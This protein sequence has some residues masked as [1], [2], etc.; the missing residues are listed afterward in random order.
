M[1]L[2]PQF[3]LSL[4]IPLGHLL[5]DLH[6]GNSLAFC[7]PWTVEGSLPNARCSGKAIYMESNEA[8]AAEISLAVATS[9]ARSNDALSLVNVILVFLGSTNMAL[10]CQFLGA[11]VVLVR[12]RHISFHVYLKTEYSLYTILQNKNMLNTDTI[13]YALFSRETLACRRKPAIKP[14]E[15]LLACA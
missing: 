3:S 7:F 4:K 1:P 2:F 9:S 10:E 6:L 15:A 12:K 8:E 5:I 11:F 14:N 13:M